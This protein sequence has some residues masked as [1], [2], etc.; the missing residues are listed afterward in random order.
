MGHDY[1]PYQARDGDIVKPEEPLIH[2][3]DTKLVEM[4][5]SWSLD[6]F[7][8]FQ[9]YHGDRYRNQGL[10]MPPGAGELSATSPTCGITIIE[11]ALYLPSRWI[12]R[13]HHDHAGKLIRALKMA[14]PASS[15]WKEGGQYRAVSRQPQRTRAKDL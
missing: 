10:R 5:I 4:P 2:G 3:P 15:R 14:A 13:R 11:Y 9:Y 8:A 12:G 7:P 6:D 1:L